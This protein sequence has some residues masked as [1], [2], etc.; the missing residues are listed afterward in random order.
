M[1]YENKFLTVVEEEKRLFINIFKEYENKSTTNASSL[2]KWS[3]Q[4]N[5][6]EKI[7]FQEIEGLNNSVFKERIKQSIANQ[8]N[9]D[10][11]YKTCDYD[12][13][14]YFIDKLNNENCSKKAF[15]YNENYCQSIIDSI[16]SEYLKIVKYIENESN[17]FENDNNKEFAVLKNKVIKTWNTMFETK[18]QK[19]IDDEYNLIIKEVESKVNSNFDSNKSVEG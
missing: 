10:K 13:F 19:I 11:N 17:R 4:R 8:K 9:N 1:N 6:V 12:K 5:S 16:A 2:N 7:V 3:K 14:C 15:K 18:L